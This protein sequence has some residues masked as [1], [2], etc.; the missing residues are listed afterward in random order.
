[1]AVPRGS[2]HAPRLGAT[3]LE[4]GAPADFVLMRANSPELGIGELMADLVY[5]AGGAAVA[6]VVVHG[7]IV[8]RD[9]EVPELEEIVARA[10]ERARGLGL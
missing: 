9:G 5:A 7:E 2:S 3:L 1:M 4:P 10:A 6:H 8:V